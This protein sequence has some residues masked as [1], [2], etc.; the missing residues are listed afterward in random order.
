MWQPDSHT[1]VLCGPSG[2]AHRVDPESVGDRPG[3]DAG[4]REA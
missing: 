1:T 3:G 4:S 2:L